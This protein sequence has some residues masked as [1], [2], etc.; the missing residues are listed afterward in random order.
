MQIIPWMKFYLLLFFL[1]FENKWILRWGSFHRADNS[2][3]VCVLLVRLRHCFHL[4]YGHS[5]TI[6]FFEI[7]ITEEKKINKSF[8]RNL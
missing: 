6:L 8:C 5:R 2:I 3:L 4:N 7:R 1:S